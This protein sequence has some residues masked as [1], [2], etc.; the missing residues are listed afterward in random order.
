MDINMLQKRIHKL[1][2]ISVMMVLSIL[3]MAFL[4]IDHGDDSLNHATYTTMNQ[5][6]DLCKQRISSQKHTDF[7][8]LNTW[9]KSLSNNTDIDSSLAEM[10][11]E[12][13]FT[14]VLY[15]DSQ[16]D[17]HF[18]NPSTHVEYNDLSKVYKSKVDSAF[19]GKQSAFIRKRNVITKEFVITY[20]V[21][22]Y[23]SS[24]NVT[25][26]L[27]AIS[28]LKPYANLMRKS[29]YGGN[30]YITD[31]KDFYGIQKDKE[32]KDV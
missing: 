2:I 6:I 10:K 8:L 12:N 13:A 15:I 25:G 32:S 19:L 1:L 31:L 22:V 7:V 28:S 30:L 3:V 26:V 21:P 5:E 27:S 20:I 9:A 14:S 11:K 16:R 23:D 4:F 18:T 17:I 24:K 29:I